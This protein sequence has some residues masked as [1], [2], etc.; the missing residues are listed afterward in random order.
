MPEPIQTPEDGTEVVEQ[1]TQTPAEPSQP[2]PP[3][4]DYEK[5]FKESQQE[6]DLLRGAN[7]TRETAA[8]ELTKEP[9]ESELRAAFPEWEALT[10][11]EKSI[12]TRQLKTER[13]ATS[14]ATTSA[15][16]K[17]ERIWNT[18]IDLEIAKNDQLQ[19]RAQ[20]FRQF[21]NQPK[22]RGAAM[23]LLV[24]AFLGSQSAN[25]PA[26]K[27]T[28]KPG[29]QPGNGG[30]RTPD[31]PQLLT[32]EQLQTLRKTDEKSYMKYIRTHDVSAITE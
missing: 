4:V 3:V 6:N 19:E 7:A 1:P 30:P 24:S 29:L 18:S 9:T 15:E 28:P 13:L 23:D 26:P 22:Y 12:A 25:P 17:A 32:A 31:K 5:K 20:A 8:Q 2:T 16:I 14:S 11:F 21:A 10:D 27:P